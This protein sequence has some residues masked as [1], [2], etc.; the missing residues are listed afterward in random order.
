MLGYH[1]NNIQN[2]T[3]LLLPLSGL[4]YLPLHDLNPV[5]ALRVLLPPPRG[6]LL[7]RVTARPGHRRQEHL[8]PRENMTEHLKISLIWSDE[9]KFGT[10]A[11]QMCSPIVTPFGPGQSVTLGKR[12]YSHAYLL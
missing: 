3:V 10:F 4:F 6:H 1:S 9:L 8:L 7:R 5:P 11:I 12:H 2:Y